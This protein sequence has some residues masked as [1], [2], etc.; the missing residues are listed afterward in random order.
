M[1]HMS[2]AIV[3]VA[4]MAT[5]AGCA[6]HGHDGPRASARPSL[7]TPSA[8][9][10]SE[11]PQ[12]AVRDA[13]AAYRGMWS[14][15]IAA[16]NTGT[17]DPPELARYASGSALQVLDK[18]LA[19][20]HARGLTTHGVPQITPQVTSSGPNGAP[21]SVTIGDCADDTRWLLYTKDGHPADSTPGGRHQVTATVNKAEGRWTVTA[22]AAEGAG[23]C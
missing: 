10:S 14:A 12:A 13:V 4:I 18:G 3:W 19:D 7:G 23:T 8:T 5:A 22:F 2:R 20:N 11:S 1:P 16:S 6:S 15:Y 17:T 9:A 21:T